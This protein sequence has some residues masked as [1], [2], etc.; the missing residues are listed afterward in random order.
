MTASEMAKAG[1]TYGAAP[2]NQP[3]IPV[4]TNAANS[5]IPPNNQQDTATAT[6]NFIN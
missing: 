2:N 4:N 1:I 3:D 5:G 6:T